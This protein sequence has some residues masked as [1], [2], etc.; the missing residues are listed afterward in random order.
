MY[1]ENCFCVYLHVNKINLKKYVGITSKAPEDRWGKNGCHY[2]D[3]PRFYNAIQKYSWNNFA[4]FIIASNLSHD[5]ACYYEKYLIQ[6]FNLQDDKFGYNIKEGGQGGP[7]ENETKIKIGNAN[8]GRKA[9]IETK[10][11]LSEAH[12]GRK[13]TQEERENISKANKGKKKPLSWIENRIGL[14]AGEKHPLFGKHPSEET[15]RKRTA[16]MRKYY[17]MHPFPAEPKRKQV[18]LVETGEIFD[19]IEKAAK[20]KNIIRS[21][22]SECCSGKRK[23]A[24]GFHWKFVS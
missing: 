24:G 6:K 7:I 12:K 22:I 9:S 1:T 10:K 3:S 20:Q 4:H 11:K 19:S 21:S 13:H 16:S 2:I 14:K 18:I 23:T 8:R 15:T 17:S 5:E